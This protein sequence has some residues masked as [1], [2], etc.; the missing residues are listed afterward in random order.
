MNKEVMRSNNNYLC[1]SARSRRSFESAPEHVRQKTQIRVEVVGHSA[2]VGVLHP[3]ALLP[4]GLHAYAQ[5]QA[6]STESFRQLR[7]ARHRSLTR[8][9]SRSLRSLGRAKARPLT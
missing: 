9:S 4:E 6:S 5:S 2:Y 1:Q 3:H 7:L 8:H